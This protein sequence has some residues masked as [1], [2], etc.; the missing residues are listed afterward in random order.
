MKSVQSKKFTKALSFVLAMCFVFCAAFGSTTSAIG[1]DAAALQNR[2]QKIQQQIK[3]AEA[4]INKISAEKKETEEYISALD[5]KILLIQDKIDTLQ[6]EADVLQ[7]QIDALQ[8]EINRIESE[9]NDIQNQIADKQKAFDKTYEE[10]CQRLRAMYVSGH[11]SNLEV[12]LTCTDMSSM[13]TRAEMI[14][15]VSKQDS[16]TLNTLMQQMQEIETQKADLEA[17]RQKLK[18]DKQSVQTQKSKL[19]AN[20]ADVTASRRELDNE[21]AECNALI[22][23]LA[24]QQTEYMETISANENEV[25]E[26]ERQIKAAIAAAQQPAV[27]PNNGGS[28]N[29]PGGTV[30]GAMSGATSGN[31]SY[32]GTFCYPTSYH[33]I[34]GDYPNYSNGRYHG[35]IDF[36]CPVGTTVV[37]SGSGTVI[38]SGWNA[39][40][41]GYLIMIDHGNGLVSLYGHNSQC[42]ASKGQKVTKGQVVAKSGNTGRSTGPH[43]HFEVRVNGTRV[44]PKNYL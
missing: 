38:F 35:G 9:I 28:G 24:G 23:K 33:T 44:N 5:S 14:K 13:L 42:I 12:L 2:K 17:K 19:D 30:S 15:S 37:A 32:S 34:S 1:A 25:D 29:R 36:P 7:S 40:G 21:V 3:D 31:G 22:K 10:Y 8:A 39:G 27:T 26:I 43:V 20:I 6:S 4:K 18:E 41:Y 16:D 11:V